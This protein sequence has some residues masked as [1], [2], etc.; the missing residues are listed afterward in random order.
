LLFFIKTLECGFA[1]G[2]GSKKICIMPRKHLSSHKGIC[3][4]RGNQRRVSGR[5]KRFLL[6]PHAEKIL[7]HTLIILPS[8][9]MQ[10]ALSV[11]VYRIDF[12]GIEP[13]F[14]P[15]YIAVS[16]HANQAIFLRFR[17]AYTCSKDHRQ[18]HKKKGSSRP[19]QTIISMHVKP[20]HFMY[21]HIG[22]KT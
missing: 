9:D 21:R 17:L 22:K 12:A 11:I 7:R 20:P 15:V 5:I 2:I 4:G 16:H 19:F 18:K 1:V 8:S 3:I 6:R 14:Y 13:G 10:Q